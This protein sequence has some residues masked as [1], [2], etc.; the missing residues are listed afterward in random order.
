MLPPRSVRTFL[1]LWFCGTWA[2][3]AAPAYDFFVCANINRNYVIGSKIVTT[4]GVFQRAAAGEW[5]HLGYNDTSVRAVDFDP[6]NRAVIFTAAN[7][8]CW[9]SLD[10][11]QHWR[12]TT[13][14][15][16][17][18]PLDVTIDPHAPDTVYL[19]LPDGIAVSPDRGQ[20]W[21][22]RENGLPERGKYTQVVEV[23]RT[24][25]G[26]VLAGCESGI[27]LTTNGAESWTRVLPTDTTV[28]DIKQSPHDPRLWLAVTQSNGAWISRD[29]GL[30]WKQLAG[31]PS[32]HALYNVAFD[33]LHPSRLAIGSW[34]LGVLT[35]EDGGETWT[36]RNAGIPDPH[37]VW[38][39]AVDPDS[40]S[41]YAS[42]VGEALYSSEDFGRTWKRGGLEAS[43][44]NAFLFLPVSTP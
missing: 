24:Q 1:G 15:D 12:I 36:A 28:D 16:M 34:T 41:L 38:R 43:T 3:A 26:R 35:S 37:K 4:N 40:G 30:S 21:P 6:R 42:V 9:R 23:D 7:N 19:A 33:P 22:R 29:G 20:T 18:E 44:V 5:Q 32:A 31:V 39:I 27:Y 11:G 10:G 14:W 17:T 25:A 13:S 8:G 2:A